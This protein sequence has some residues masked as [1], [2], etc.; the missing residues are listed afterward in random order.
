ME[1]EYT[2]DNQP[3]P[4]GSKSDIRQKLE[5]LIADE[6]AQKKRTWTYYQE[7]RH[8]DPHKYLM[9]KIQV[10]MMKDAA[11]LGEAFKD[12]DYNAI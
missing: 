3:S 4:A 1:E 2:N 8:K 12:G 10:Q 9:P 7:I 11:A 6:E 5:K